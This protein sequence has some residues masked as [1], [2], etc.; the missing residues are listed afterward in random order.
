MEYSTG[1][2]ASLR[3]DVGRPDHLA[4]LLGLVGNVLAE[5]GGRHRHWRAAQVEQP[6][7]DL[8]VGESGVNLVVQLVNDAG[9]R[10][11]GRDDAEPAG[12]LV[13]RNKLTDSRNVG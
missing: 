9:R 8:F 2:R 5:V 3:L 4:P 10:V 12:R 7:R 11:L 6:G 13:D 1:S